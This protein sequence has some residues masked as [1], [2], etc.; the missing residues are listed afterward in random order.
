MIIFFLLQAKAM[1]K[2][3]KETS[4]WAE[5]VNAWDSIADEDISENEA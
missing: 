2:R 3:E 1:E 4:M 5:F